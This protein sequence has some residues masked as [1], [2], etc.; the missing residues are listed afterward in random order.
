MRAAI[1]DLE[2]AVAAA[3]WPEALE[4]ALAL[5]RQHRWWSLAELVDELGARCPRLDPPDGKAFH[6]WWIERAQAARPADVTSLVALVET[7]AAASSVSWR[8]IAARSDR[9]ARAL[10]DHVDRL[11]RPFGAWLELVDRIGVLLAWADDPRVALA[12][13]SWLGKPP[14]KPREWRTQPAAPFARVAG[15][16]VERLRELADLRTVP[17]LSRVLGRIDRTHELAVAFRSLP[18][19]DEADDASVVA[20]LARLRAPA[21]GPG[22]P[23]LAALWAAVAEQPDAL[24][25]RLVLA[26]ALQERGDPRG[27]LI[28][29]QCQPRIALERDPA[30]DR[31]ALFGEAGSRA[32]PILDGHRERWLG[33]LATVI[34][35][36]SMFREGL[37]DTIYLGSGYAPSWVYGRHAGHRELVAVQRVAA[38]DVRAGELAAFVGSLPRP[39]RWLV[40]DGPLEEK[41][42]HAGITLDVVGL[43]CRVFVYERD[44]LG[45]F[46]T[47]A[48]ISP[49]VRFIRLPVWDDPSHASDLVAIAQALPRLYARLERILIR[50]EHGMQIPAAERAALA[51]LPL[52]DLAA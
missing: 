15:A 40:I 51:A 34:S 5:W 8:T 28:A 17:A 26:D 41:L 6:R 16:I 22:E 20:C 1:A 27:E 11:A 12:L 2:A 46:R 18:E 24:A 31:S 32:R 10:G 35:P 3:R 49:G 47:F 42:R 48:S 4:I 44:V 13:A 45:V 9:L 33:E 43:E 14:F 38:N 52:D 29:V 39:L 21:S 50:P 37:L 30:A 36:A 19:P 25:P 23:A 7:R